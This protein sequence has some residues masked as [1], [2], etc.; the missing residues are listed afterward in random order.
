MSLPSVQPESASQL[1]DADQQFVKLVVEGIPLLIVDCFER[2]LREAESIGGHRPEIRSRITRQIR[3]SAARNL[4]ECVSLLLARA[5][6]LQVCSLC[7]SLWPPNAG[8]DRGFC[9][10]P[11]RCRKK[12]VNSNRSYDAKILGVMEDASPRIM[13]VEEIAARC[14]RKKSR[15]Y[16]SLRRLERAG[17]VVKSLSGWTAVKRPFPSSTSP[18]SARER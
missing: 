1:S 6:G 13:P 7:G 15:V 17:K 10:L 2:A 16:H 14:A 9:P 18:T 5:A 11:A 8:L 12:Y 3:A 4:T